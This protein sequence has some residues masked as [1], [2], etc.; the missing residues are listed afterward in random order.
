MVKL[1][2]HSVVNRH[3]A[4]LVMHHLTEMINDKLI[5]EMLLQPE[6]ITEVMNLH[7]QKNYDM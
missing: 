7:K 1:A 6:K 3:Q 4:F 5:P 2:M